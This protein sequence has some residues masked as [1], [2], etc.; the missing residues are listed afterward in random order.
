M[1][2]KIKTLE[3]LF[4]CISTQFKVDK[5]HAGNEQPKLLRLGI[6]LAIGP[7]DGLAISL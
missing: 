2:V 4:P 7:P 3:G 5:R 6:E 1:H